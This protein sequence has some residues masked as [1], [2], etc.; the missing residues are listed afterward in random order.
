[1]NNNNLKF[2]KTI[3]KQIKY[4]DYEINGL[5]YEEAIK[6]DKRTF[7]EYYFSLLKR[8]QLLIFTFYINNDYNS[9]CIKIC[10]FLFS[11]ALFFTVNALFFDDDTIHKIYIDK[12]KYSFI[13]QIPFIIYSTIISSIINGIIKYLSLSENDIIEIKTNKKVEMNVIKKCI[14]IKVILFFVF[15]FLLFFFLVLYILFLCYL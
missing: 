6:I 12:G 9:R 7:I 11:F 3:I 8:K 15:K 5:K 13:Y 4:N 14:K 10:L 1:M 2:N